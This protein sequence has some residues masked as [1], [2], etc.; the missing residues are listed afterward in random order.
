[1]FAALA[2]PFLHFL[3][4]RP[5]P[6][7]MPAVLLFALVVVARFTAL[8]FNVEVLRAG[9]QR[10]EIPILGVASLVLAVGGGLAASRGSLTGLAGTR[11]AS[12]LVIAVGY[13][14]LARSAS[15]RQAPAVAEPPR[16]AEPLRLLFLAPFP[17]SL[18]GAHGG[19]RVIAQLLDRMAGRHRVGLMC[20]KHPDDPPVDERLRR[21]LDLLVEVERRDASRSPR[22]RALRGVRARLLLLSGTPLWATELDVGAFRRRLL[23][24]LRGWRPD[25]VQVEYTAMGVYLREVGAAGVVSV[26]GEPDPPTSAAIDL[27]RASRRDRLLRRLDVRAWR[28]FEREV[29]SRVDAAVVF[30]QRDARALAAQGA[31]T[32]IVRIPF[33]TD[34]AERSFGSGAG[35]D[36]VLFVGNFVHP[37]NVD[38]AERLVRSIFPAVRRRHPGSSLHVVGDRPPVKL[39]AVAGDGVFVTG[40]VPNLVPYVERAAVVAAPIRFGGGMRVKVL[41]ALAAGKPVVAS[42][43]AVEGLDVE[44][45]DQ[46]LVA[47]SDEEFAERIA[48]LLADPELRARLGERARAWARDNLTWDAAVERHERLYARLLAA[49]LPA[50]ARPGGAEALGV[51]PDL[52]HPFGEGSARA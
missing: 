43:L 38:A 16:E 14:L 29:L 22:A 12:E 23:D 4:H 45:G 48:A 17:P 35:D 3:L 47:D 10:D 1:V 25:I 13:V 31:A 50:P 6:D 46:L 5:L 8:V 40:R 21:R 2:E 11:L 36:D 7:L 44:D 42:S 52:G 39:R 34:F 32:E 30:T 24:V 20:L 9:R 37:P 27:G 15:A 18:D 51:Q 41:E 49:R 26:L 33:G 28:R 19:S